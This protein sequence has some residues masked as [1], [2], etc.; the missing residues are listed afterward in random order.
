MSIRR[1]GK[2]M[3]TLILLLGLGLAAYLLVAIWR[4]EKF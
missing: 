3:N 4:P 1:V 2:T